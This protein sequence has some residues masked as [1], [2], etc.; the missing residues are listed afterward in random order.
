MT[1]GKQEK[2]AAGLLST[3]LYIW[4]ERDDTEQA[5]FNCD[6]CEFHLDDGRCLAKRF[7][8]K[9]IE[10]KVDMPQG[11]IAEPCKEGE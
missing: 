2:V 8:N 4:C 9:H 1:R 3:M 7:V 11:M 5:E 6:I 10:P